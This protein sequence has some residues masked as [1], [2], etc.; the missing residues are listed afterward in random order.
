MRSAKDVEKMEQLKQQ[1]QTLEQQKTAVSKMIEDTSRM[2]LRV[3]EPSELAG[4]AVEQALPAISLSLAGVGIMPFTTVPGSSFVINGSISGISTLTSEKLSGADWST[5][6]GKAGFNFMTAGALG[7]YVGNMPAEKI[8]LK[9]RTAFFGLVGSS[10][11][12]DLL[13]NNGNVNF[14]K[15]LLTGGFGAAGVGMS[16]WIGIDANLQD[17]WQNNLTTAF[18]TA[19]IYTIQW[20]IDSAFNF[21]KGTNK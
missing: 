16:S 5:A 9:T 19:P 11:T 6:L 8:W 4:K 14:K 1:I 13:F 2:L 10:V 7:Q 18:V 15:A 20:A 3:G 17:V 21:S 12:G